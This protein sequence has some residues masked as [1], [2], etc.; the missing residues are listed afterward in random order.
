MLAW[1]TALAAIFPVIGK[2][3][4]LFTTKKPVIDEEND[5]KKKV[6]QEAKE[7]KDS[8]RPS[9]DFWKDRHL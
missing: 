5:E 9:G 2:L 1:L 8:K 7:N 3:I 6:D 4:D